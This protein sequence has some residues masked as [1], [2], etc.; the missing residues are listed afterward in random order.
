MADSIDD[1]KLIPLIK[2][3]P[4]MKNPISSEKEMGLI[5]VVAFKPA[6][7]RRSSGTAPADE[8]M[9]PNV[10]HKNE[11][12][13]HYTAVVKRGNSWIEYDDLT[14]QSR[15]RKENSKIVPHILIYKNVGI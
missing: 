11:L 3:P 10:E 14:C 15:G 12:L 4:M 1:N 6:G 9:D 8:N 2:L 7:L 13:G 5:G